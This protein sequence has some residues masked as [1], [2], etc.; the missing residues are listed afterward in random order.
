MVSE[1][2]EDAA[3]IDAGHEID[4]AL[5]RALALAEQYGLSVRERLADAEQ[6]WEGGDQ[7]ME[8][9]LSCRCPVYV[10]VDLGERVV[11]KV[12]V[13]DEELGRPDGL[14]AAGGDAIR[15]DREIGVAAREVFDDARQTWPA[16][17]FGH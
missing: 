10:H 7:S 2:T 14:F 15:A 4:D 1:L 13:A 11:T 8:V 5:D 9:V 6:R 12:V 16:W 3:R 17:Q